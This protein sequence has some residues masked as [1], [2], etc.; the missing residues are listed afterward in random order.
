VDRDSIRGWHQEGSPDTLMRARQEVGRLLSGYE[1]PHLPD[2]KVN[3]LKK[4]VKV[5]AHHAGLDTL[6]SFE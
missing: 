3:E 5:Q 4:L 1:L 6:P 2:D